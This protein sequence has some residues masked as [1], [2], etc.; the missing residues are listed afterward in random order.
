MDLLGLTAEITLSYVENHNVSAG[1]LPALIKGIHAGLANSGPIR[2]PAEASR[3]SPAVPISKSIADDHLICLEEGHHFKSLKRH[4]RIKHDMT[5]EQYRAKWGLPVS[6]RWLRRLTQPAVRRL[7]RAWASAGSGARLAPPLR[8][9]AA[10]AQPNYR[11]RTRRLGLSS[12]GSVVPGRPLA[13]RAPMPPPYR[14]HSRR[15]RPTA[16]SRRK[17]CSSV[18]GINYRSPVVA[19]NRFSH[20]LCHLAD[21]TKI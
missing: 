15:R 19:A 5:P 18:L 11:R 2:A 3:R 4:L 1:D 9:G 14:V 13:E 10:R 17:P 12:S 7:P 6:Y 21:R 8:R 16:V 20:P